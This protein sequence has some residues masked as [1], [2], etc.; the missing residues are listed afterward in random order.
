MEVGIIVHNAGAKATVENIVKTA[1]W[2]EELGYHS[3]WLT[4]HVVLAEE[5]N[6]WY[7]YRVHAAGIIPP[8]RPG[9]I[10]C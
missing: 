7:P 2:A 3:I 1:R 4:D 10:H 8:I 6:A 9:L 5:V